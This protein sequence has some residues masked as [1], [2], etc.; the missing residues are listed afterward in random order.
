MNSC[1][2]SSQRY[3]DGPS[4]TDPV[5]LDLSSMGKGMVWI[6]GQA[7]G[8]YWVNY[9]SPLGKPSQYM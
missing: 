6:N 8:R 7:I 9:L 3:F 1:H 5:A 4:G 2:L